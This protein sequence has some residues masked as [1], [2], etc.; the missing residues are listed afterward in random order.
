M[1][2]EYGRGRD[3]TTGP[4]TFGD[5]IYGDGPGGVAPLTFGYDKL[6]DF[7]SNINTV[8]LNKDYEPSTQQARSYKCPNCEGE[9]NSWRKKY[10]N[11]KGDWVDSQYIIGSTR[12]TDTRKFCPFCD[13]KR[14]NYDE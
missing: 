13:M 12:S 9:F 5:T 7:D 1:T 3:R 8:T 14:G 11:A 2:N 10:M 4:L 6:K